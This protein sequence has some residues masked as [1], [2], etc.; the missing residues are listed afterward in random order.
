MEH[1]IAT[2][3]RIQSQLKSMPLFLGGHRPWNYTEDTSSNVQDPDKINVSVFGSSLV[4]RLLVFANTNPMGKEGINPQLNI[5]G[6][7]VNWC[8]VPGLKLSRLLHESQAGINFTERGMIPFMAARRCEPKMAVCLWGGN[9]VDNIYV[10]PITVSETSITFACL[11]NC[12]TYVTTILPRPCPTFAHPQDYNVTAQA[13]NDD[14]FNKLE[15]HKN[16]FPLV[17]LWKIRR[18]DNA[19]IDLFNEDGV[20]PNDDGNLRLYH[21]IRKAVIAGIKKL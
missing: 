3:A 21:N 7:H 19:A 2:I 13:V 11:F 8:G 1:P 10:N 15:V 16:Y 6:V 12:L 4:A 5:P 20:H 9:D 18:F 14:L 17:N